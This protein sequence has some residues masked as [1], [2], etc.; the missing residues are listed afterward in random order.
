M[1][2]AEK[3]GLRFNRYAAVALRYRTTFLGTETVP[4]NSGD[5]D[6]IAVRN[7]LR[8]M[9]PAWTEAWW[10]GHSVMMLSMELDPRSRRGVM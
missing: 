9:S 2:L 6:R 4:S 5:R 7:S 1:N 8:D 10:F 3:I